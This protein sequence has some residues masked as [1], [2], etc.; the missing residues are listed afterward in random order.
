VPE[1]Y[2]DPN[3]ANNS[4]SATVVVTQP[5]AD[6]L[7]TKTV[8][9][10]SAGPYSSSLSVLTGQ[11]IYFQIGIANNGP[12]IASNVVIHDLLPPGLTYVTNISG[13]NGF[14]YSTKTG[15][16]TIGTVYPNSGTAYMYLDALCTNA[17]TFT[18]FATAPVPAGLMDPNLTNNSAS[19]VVT[20]TLPQ[21]DLVVTKGVS[22]NGAGPY[23]SSLSVVAGQT[24]YFQIG[25]ANNGPN[26]ASNVVI[27]DRLPPGLNYVT[28]NSAGNPF[29]YNAATGVWTVGT[30]S[31]GGTS[32]MYLYAIGT[33]TGTF[34]NTATAPVPAGLI[35]PNLT[36]NSAS[37]V[38]QIYPVYSLSG[39]VRGCQTNGSA[40]PFTTVNLTGAATGSTLSGTNGFFSFSNLLSGSYTVTPVQPGNTFTPSSATVNLNANTTLPVFL[41]AVGQIRGQLSYGTNG[42]VIA[43]APVTLSGATNRTVLTDGN[44]V[45]AFTNTPPGTYTVTPVATNGYGFKPT[46]AV[47]IIS[48]TNCTGQASFSAAN[49]KVLLVALEVVQVS[50]DWS[51]S[52]PLIQ[53]KKTFVR[54]H[55][56]LPT[57]GPA[58]LLQGARLYGMGQAGALAGSP[59]TPYAPGRSPDFLVQTTN[60][61]A[62]R[63]TFNNSLNFDIPPGWTTGILTLQLVATNNVT[64]VP[65]NTVSANSSVQV[66]FVSTV[67]PPLKFFGFNLTNWSTLDFQ[68]VNAAT[69]ATVPARV[70]SIYPVPDITATRSV[71]VPPSTLNVPQAIPLTIPEEDRT[72]ADWAL[73][74]ANA[75]LL[76]M[77]ALDWLLSLRFGYT[78]WIYCGILAGPSPG[79]YGWAGAFVTSSNTEGTRAQNVSSSYL[80]PTLYGPGSARQTIPHEIGHNLGFP[81]DVNFRIFGIN[82]KGFAI[83]S[84]NT[85]LTNGYQ[86]P[87][88]QPIPPPNGGLKPTLGPMTN[89][90][91]NSLVYGLDTFTLLNFP[92]TEPVANPNNC[93]D[94]M[95]YCR[96]NSP[97][98]RWNSTANY[99]GLRNAINTEFPPPPPPPPPGPPRQWRFIRG[100]VDADT[101]VGGFEPFWTV[102]STASTA[103]PAPPPGDYVAALLDANGTVIEAIPFTPVPFII[104]E[105]EAEEDLFSIPLLDN[106]AIHGVEL[107]DMLNNTI[108]A[109]IVAPANLPSV[110]SVRLSAPN[111]APFTGSGPL[112]AQWQ[113]LDANPG[114]QLA[115]LIQ[116][117]T[118][119]GNTWDTLDVDWPGTSY[120][121]DS[122]YL[123]ATTQGMIR[124]IVSDGFNSSAPA[125]SSAFTIPNHPPKVSLNSP[126]D[127]EI[128]IADGQ[129]VFDVSAIDP[130]DGPLDGARVQW[131]SS[132]DGF[133]GYGPVLN[134]E[135]DLLSEGTQVITVT[136]TDGEGLS[137]SAQATI[138]VLRQTPPALTI[139]LI[140][141][142]L[143]LNWPSSV[144]NYALE[145]TT[146]LAPSN[147]TSITNVPFAADSTQTVYLNLSSTNRFF[148][149]RMP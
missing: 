125:D 120:Q 108:V 74:N 89:G 51:N 93:F 40:V 20:V 82:A 119:G 61:S 149:L 39:F 3:L 133:L 116:Y 107:V 55:L 59:L 6:L 95:S 10:N 71:L 7:V 41:G 131:S 139:Q 73:L 22:T 21:A 137:S 72:P 79:T 78:N 122:S 128:L 29:T 56:Q 86:F 94:M 35:D 146:S 68:T 104:E 134:L 50:Q 109:N 147:W 99:I 110:S 53:A 127:G 58:V 103:P 87:T 142:Q 80:Q 130:Q 16:W 126:A 75:K 100:F 83:G 57:N 121:V 102:T 31:P 98:E 42:A 45:Y 32:F 65:T 67:V 113:A 145:S 18:N 88:F 17:G 15:V 47:V 69:Y 141:N 123:Q 96:S 36:N 63:G 114:A 52:V 77:Q 34:T 124:V 135:A 101:D 92:G 60:A 49:R 38:V 9:T 105:T 37:A 81:H 132:R 54:A 70:T 66:T 14:T 84:C 140:G 8:S 13:A 46:N 91:P 23:T 27:N 106:P 136:A 64:V 48:V 85:G 12:N 148:R 129:A 25:I 5:A 115:Y 44:G 19:A 90:T 76:Q 111:G 97:L 138:Y 4:A 43:G 118:D 112:V 143:E 117:S 144:T 11:M 28:N 62:L 33:N 24:M 2:T 26:L 1:G 30:V